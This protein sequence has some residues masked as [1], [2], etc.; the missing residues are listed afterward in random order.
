MEPLVRDLAKSEE[1]WRRA[2]QIIPAGTQTMS[3]GPTQ[4][5]DG[6]APKYIRRGKG[7][8]VW[9]VDGNEYIDYG[10]GLRPLVLGYSYPAV[11]EAIT[12][13]LKEGITF[14][15]MHPLEV[16]LSELLIKIIPCAEMVRFGKNGSDVTS[17]AI[18]LARAYTGRDKILCCGYHGWQDWYAATTERNRGIPKAVRKLSFSFPYN[19]TESLERLFA[20]N[21]GQVAAVIMEPVGV[22]P[23][24]D[25]FL[26][27]VKK[28]ANENSAVLIFDEIIT[29][30]RFA[31]G[32]AQEYFGVIPDLA[33]FGKGMANG[34]PLSALVG[35]REIMKELESVFFSLTFG[36]EVLSLAASVATIKEIKERNVIEHLWKQGR[37]L[38]DGYNQLAREMA[39]EN[40]T[41]CI[42]YAPSTLVTFREAQGKDSLALK[43]L[44]QQE[45]IK[46]GVLFTGYHSMSYAHSDDD[47][48]KTLEVYGDA[49]RILKKAVT[50]KDITKYL[51][52]KPVQPVFRSMQLSP[53]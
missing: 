4:F 40:H 51:E 38:Q 28:L 49:M 53:R 48:D 24:V 23:P 37:K 19:D 3:K 14:T 31:L 45:A 20:E 39:L 41:R 13:Q 34:M 46:R 11:D 8:H 52:G 43:S 18:R 29:G 44:F 27:R 33:T 25:N 10:M 9:D 21:K 17:A 42:G 16:E 32:G 47:I 35:R 12:E 15:L 50:E 22:E 30:F 6:V 7:C 2:E 5:V 1:Y 36:G 26:E